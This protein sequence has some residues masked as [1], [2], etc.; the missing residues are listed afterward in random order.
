MAVKQ[1]GPSASA[2]VPSKLDD[3][4][5]KF[6]GGWGAGNLISNPHR[7]RTVENLNAK[8]FGSLHSQG[9]PGQIVKGKGVWKDGRWRVTFERSLAAGNKGDVEF[10]PGQS[11]PVGFAVWDGQAGDRNGQKSV[12]IWHDLALA[13]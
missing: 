7:A 12:T 8:G 4:D 5:P 6:Y 3:R 1:L 2:T 9:L 10:R 11:V 13:Q